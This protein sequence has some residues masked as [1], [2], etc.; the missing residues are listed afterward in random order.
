MRWRRTVL[1]AFLLA[2]SWALA[3]CAADACAVCYGAADS[4]LTEGVNNG[5]LVLLAV[6]A[7]VQVGFVAL[8]VSIRQRARRERRR[9]DRFQLIRGGAG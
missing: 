6:I 1:A 2:V 4:P 7:V 3:P 9:N 5:I 8:F